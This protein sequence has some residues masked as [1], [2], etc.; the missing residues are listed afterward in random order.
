MTENKEDIQATEFVI[1]IL[2]KE[3]WVTEEILMMYESC[4]RRLRKLAIIL[5]IDTMEFDKVRDRVMKKYN[6]L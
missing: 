6:Q 5:E 1:N 4:Y 3:S 2:N